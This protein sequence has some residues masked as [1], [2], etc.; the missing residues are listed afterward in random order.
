MKRA[1]LCLLMAV[2]ITQSCKD[3]NNDN[4]EDLIVEPELVTEQNSN[5][6]KAIAKYMEEHY[7]DNQGLI[8]KIDTT[9]STPQVKLADLNPETLPSGVI[10][11]KRPGAQPSDSQGTVIG[12]TDVLRIMHN[13][14]TFLSNKEDDGK[15]IYTSSYAFR[16]TID[17]SGVPEVDPYFYY[18]KKAVLEKEGNTD[19]MKKREYYEIEGLQEGLKHFKGFNIE[20]SELH[21]LQGVIIV[22]SRA[23]YA[24]D[25]HYTSSY[26][27]RSFVFN[28]QIY[29]NTAR[30]SSQE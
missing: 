24:R 25:A 9:K 18:V 22:P 3:D 11:I 26:R 21:N 4:Y 28:F 8:K 12:N 20:D 2:A 15:I 5:D 13:T 14:T 27:N 1:L 6:D 29:K 17:G 30:T 16:N 19:D 23:A 7:L 10:V